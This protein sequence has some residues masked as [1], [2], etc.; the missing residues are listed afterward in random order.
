MRRKTVCTVRKLLLQELLDE[1]DYVYENPDR[2]K[3]RRKQTPVGTEQPTDSD[4]ATQSDDQGMLLFRFHFKVFYLFV[5]KNI[6]MK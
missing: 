1:R 6:I 3:R 5:F 2:V 4:M